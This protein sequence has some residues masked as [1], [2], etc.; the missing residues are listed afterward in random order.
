MANQLTIDSVSKIYPAARGG[1]DVQALD[2]V[3][4]KVLD[5]EFVSIVG[6]SGCGKSTLLNLVAGLESLTSGSIVVCDKVVTGP[7]PDV[8]IVFQEARLLP[9]RTVLD[10]VCFGL[11]A[12][13]VPKT[14]RNKLAADAL[15]TMALGEFAHRYPRQ[16][17]G[18]M[19]QRVAIAR[20]WVL[21]TPILLMDEPFG[22]LDA[23]TRIIMGEVLE[24]IYL[25]SKKTVVFVTHDIEE[26]VFLSD[27]VVTMSARPG[28]VLQSV[29]IDLA[30]PRELSL[31]S[32]NRFQEYVNVVWND[33]AEETKRSFFANK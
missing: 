24:E 7:S 5:G 18:G 32:D 23:Q 4:I 13:R 10:N 14:R 22:A 9:W 3:T 30:R 20:A 27:I 26:A 29:Q 28:R 2:N 1:Q 25:S 12:R 8:G 33:I 6:P 11:K 17:S 21:D 16:L 19:Q 15:Q 31:R